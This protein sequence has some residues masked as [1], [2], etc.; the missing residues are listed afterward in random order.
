MR[1]HHLAPLLLAAWICPFHIAMASEGLLELLSVL[2][3]NGSITEKEY[4][5]LAAVVEDDID[6][7]DESTGSQLQIETKGG[8]EVATYDGEFSFQLG[9]RI[10]VD[11]AYYDEDL[12]ELGSGTELRRARIDLEGTM[13]GD[14]GYEFGVDF[15]DKDADIKDA[16]ISY[17]GFDPWYFQVGQFKEPFSLEE[18]TSSRY[19][20]FMERALPNELAPGRHIGIGAR[21]HWDNWT[22]AAGVFGEAFDDD[23]DDEGNEG[24]ALTG[25]LTYAPWHDDL[26]ALHLGGALSRRWT[27][28]DDTVK[29]S[30][31][32]ESH[33]TDVKYLNTGKIKNTDSVDRLGLEAAWVTGPWSLQ[34]EYII[35]DLNRSGGFDDP[36][37]HGWYV[38]GSWF[39]T[40][41][42]R[43]YKFKKGSFGRVKP[44]SR[45]GAWELVARFS[46]M[47]LDDADI[48]GGREQNWTLGANWYINPHLRLMANYTRVDNNSTADDDGDVLGNDDPSVFQTRIQIDF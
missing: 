42:S 5:K 21:R 32:P 28:D 16:Y 45:Y 39:P 23:A 3:D 36:R 31:R 12:N 9:G 44:Q 48:T 47:D 19:I 22:A 35:S 8:L 41:E 10:M 15:S 4:N 27:D 18:L 43:N 30:T 7:Q 38:Y 2:R 24:W 17:M 11:G 25:R 26:R 37:F 29:Y 40:G 34:G 33:I 6:A 1:F 14:W 13:F 46:S 20:S